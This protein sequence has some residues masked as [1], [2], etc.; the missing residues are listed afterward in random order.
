MEIFK[1]VGLGLVATIIAILLNQYKPEYKIFVS[2]AAGIIIILLVL[3]KLVTVFEIIKDIIYRLDVEA[4]YLR[5]IFKIIA[6]AY[7]A[8]FGAQI[9]EDCGEGS[10]ATKIEFAG[11]VIIIVLA[12]PIMLAVLDLVTGLIS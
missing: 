9:C 1:I 8:E 2:T 5:S 12:L 3:T 6:I 4:V 7:V 11:K 10:I